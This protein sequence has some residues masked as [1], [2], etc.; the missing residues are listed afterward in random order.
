[1]FDPEEPILEERLIFLG[2]ATMS[3]RLTIIGVML[4]VSITAAPAKRHHPKPCRLR[5]AWSLH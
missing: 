5:A 1:M 3:K 2:G 4:L